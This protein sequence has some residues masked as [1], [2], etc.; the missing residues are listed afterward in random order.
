MIHSGNIGWCSQA[1]EIPTRCWLL[2]VNNSRIEKK[3]IS[4][5][6]TSLFIFIV[7]GERLLAGF[8]YGCQVLGSFICTTHSGASAFT[9][10]V[11]VCLTHSLTADMAG[12]ISINDVLLCIWYTLPLAVSARLSTRCSRQTGTFEQWLRLYKCL[13]PCKAATSLFFTPG[14]VSV[15]FKF[16]QVGNYLLCFEII[17]FYVGVS[18]AMGTFGPLDF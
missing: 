5:P 1:T 16:S 13:L 11:P 14:E 2:S 10:N 6:I 9:P 4:K 17:D 8:S 12:T 15:L 3:K 18:S 7:H